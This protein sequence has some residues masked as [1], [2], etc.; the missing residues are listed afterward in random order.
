MAFTMP[1]GIPTPTPVSEYSL[2]QTLRF[3]TP[4]PAGSVSFLTVISIILGIVLATGSV[5]GVVGKA[6]FVDRNEYNLQVVTNA[7]ERGKVTET[8]K[9]LDQSIARLETSMEKISAS[10]DNFKDDDR[11]AP[12]R[13]GR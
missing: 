10:L 5:V 9:R 2:P 4:K 1:E 12:R 6:F 11:T 3:E 13:R 8:L 7:E